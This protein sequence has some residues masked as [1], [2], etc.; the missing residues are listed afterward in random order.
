M[1]SV[2]LQDDALDV[3]HHLEESRF[4]AASSQNAYASGTGTAVVGG[5]RGSP[6]TREPG[7]E[8]VGSSGRAAGRRAPI[9]ACRHRR[10]T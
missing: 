10:G 8:Q 5:A 6:C 1:S 2:L 3:R 4:T 9:R 7:R